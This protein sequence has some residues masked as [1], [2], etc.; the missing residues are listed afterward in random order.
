MIESTKPYGTLYNAN[1]FNRHVYYYPIFMEKITLSLDNCRGI[2]L[3]QVLS[4]QSFN[5]RKLLF[6]H[7]LFYKSLS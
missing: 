4:Y 7:C 3:R 6:K 1:R 2:R 5:N